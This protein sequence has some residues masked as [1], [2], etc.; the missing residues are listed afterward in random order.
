MVEVVEAIGNETIAPSTDAA[1]FAAAADRIGGGVHGVFYRNASGCYGPSSPAASAARQ[2]HQVMALVAGVTPQELVPTVI[3]ALVDELTNT[4]GAASGHIDTGLHTTYFMGKLL[5]GGMDGAAP[6]GMEGGGADRPDLVYHATMNPTWPSYAALIEAGLTTWPETWAIGRIAGGVSKMHGTLNGFGLTFPQ[7]Y[8]GVTL[9][10]GALKSTTP[11]EG[12]RVRPSY[13]IAGKTLAPPPPPPTPT[14]TPPQPPQPSAP[15]LGGA[16]TECGSSPTGACTASRQLCITCKAGTGTITGITFASWGTPTGTCAAG[17]QYAPACNDTR[18][19]AI[20]AAACLGKTACCITPSAFCPHQPRLNGA[21]P[22]VRAPT[23]DPR[24][25]FAGKDPCLGKSKRLAVKA[26]G[27]EPAAPP[28]PPPPP[29]SPP[30]HT[31][32]PLTAVRGSVKTLHGALSVS[33]LDAGTTAP[34]VLNVTIPIGAAHTSVWLV[35]KAATAT[36]SGK[37]AAAAAG[38]Q[39]L[40]ETTRHGAPYS[41]WEVGSG[42]YSFASHR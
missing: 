5:S 6:G 19:Y 21:G 9:P 22:G 33:W 40:R 2:G 7:A 30:P 25:P 23:S 3:G 42:S 41:V 39:L 32:A 15:C 18:T 11:G 38:V 14:P 35:G 12:L 1:R 13:F 29:P 26:V 17:F 16:A 24:C 37:P 8:L 36:E 10:F 4:S 27:C 20:A 28:P 31:I 34:V